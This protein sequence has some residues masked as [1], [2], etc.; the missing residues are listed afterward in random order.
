[1]S[2]ELGQKLAQ[3]VTKSELE[4]IYL[5]YKPKRRTKAMI[6]RENGLEPLARKLLENRTL[7]PEVAAQEHLNAEVPDVKS[8][9]NGARDILTEELSENADLLARLR[10]HMRDNA[11]IVSKVIDGQQAAGQKFS[12][13]FDHQE[14]FSKAAGHRAL[15]MFRVETKEPC[16]SNY[17]LMLM[18][19]VGHPAQRN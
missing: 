8:A 5:P 9:L 12:D 11:Q 14:A 7:D 2:D 15:A 16:R 4:D 3:A 13:Y 10:T 17:K 19:R 6:A 1:M 18:R